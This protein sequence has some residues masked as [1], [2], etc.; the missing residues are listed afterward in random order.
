MIL[1]WT[2]TQLASEGRQSGQQTQVQLGYHGNHNRRQQRL[3]RVPPDARRRD[4]CEGMR[5]LA[6]TPK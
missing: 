1:L 6:G 4:I 3:K 5:P 2:G